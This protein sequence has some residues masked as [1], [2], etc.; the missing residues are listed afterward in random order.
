MKTLAIAVSILIASHLSAQIVKS[1]MLLASASPAPPIA[2][3]T[4]TPAACQGTCHIGWSQTADT[5]AIAQSAIYRAYIDGSQ[6]GIVLSGVTVT[7]SNSPFTAQ[8]VMPSVAPGSHTIALTAQ[9]DPLS[10]E[11]ALSDTIAFSE[12][13]VIVAPNGLFITP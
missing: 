8:A 12:V 11:S 13:V 3:P 1:P 5:L 6:T 9:A 7:G 4:P 2:T 10:P